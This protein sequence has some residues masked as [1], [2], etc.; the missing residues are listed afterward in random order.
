MN[1]YEMTVSEL[2]KLAAQ[3]KVTGRSNMKK[4]ELID[5]LE[6]CEA[7]QQTLEPET[8][9]TTETTEISA[10]VNREIPGMGYV[11]LDTKEVNTAF[12]VRTGNR[13]ELRATNG[14]AAHIRARSIAKAVKLW[15][16]VLDIQLTRIETVKQF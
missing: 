3:F 9:G 13:W 8:T 10:L 12:V 14:K 11:S 4:A 15:A 16:R 5:A 1:I 7:Y 2:R 6:M